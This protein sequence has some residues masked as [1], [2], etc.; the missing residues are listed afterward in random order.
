QNTLSDQ[1]Q[2]TLFMIVHQVSELWIKLI[3]QNVLELEEKLINN[4]LEESVKTLDDI[5][6]VQKQLNGVFE[7]LNTLSPSEYLKFRDC[8]GNASGFQ[9]FQYRMLE[10]KLGE[11]NEYF[12]SLYQNNTFEKKE[13]EKYYNLPTTNEILK[14]ALTEYLSFDSKGD[15]KSLYYEVYKNPKKYNLLYLLLE[16]II[17]IDSNFKTWRFNHM[18]TVQKIIGNKTGTGGSSGVEYL[19]KYLHR[20]FF[21]ELWDVRNIL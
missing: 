21:R 18:N 20:Q 12:L 1:T 5:I 7:V 3:F 13:L 17:L 10:Y 8:L 15:I 11:K 2:E 16:K 19:K 14:K 9:S 6:S 4:C